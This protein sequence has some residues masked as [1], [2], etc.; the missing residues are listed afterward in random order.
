MIVVLL[1]LIGLGIMVFVH[2]LGHFVAA[3]ANG[4]AVEVF[5]LGWGPRLFGFKRGGTVYQ[6]SWFPIGGYCKMR[7]EITPGIAGGTGEQSQSPEASARKPADGS[8]N[9]APP[10]RRIIISAAGPLF[11]L[12]FAVIILSIIW[13]AGFNVTSY[14]NRIV[15]ATDYALDVSSQAP[16]ATAAGLKTGDRVLSIN[17]Q[18]VEN[19]QGI[20][21]AVTVAPNDRLL[22][23]ISREDGT[24]Q[25][26]LT[27]PVTP[28]L[29]KDSGAGQIGILPWVDPVV[30]TVLPKSPASN[31]ELQAGDRILKANG[32]A[33][34]NAWDIMRAL[35]DKPQKVVLEIERQKAVQSVPLVL[36]YGGTPQVGLD[37]SQKLLGV[38]FVVRQYHSPRL[39]PVGALNH[40]LG[41]T[42]NWVTVTV[43]GFGLLFQGIN[44]RNAVAG[45]LKIAR[46]IGDTAASGFQIGIGVGLTWTF[47][48]LAILSVVLFLMNLLPI[49]A[50]DGG[51]IILF[52]I[53]VVRGKAVP[54][55]LF[56]RIQVIGFSILLALIVVVTFNDILSFVAG[57]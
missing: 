17:G 30:Q 28:R 29:D 12:A 15:L 38:D 7:G 46:D 8:F 47:R 37:F 41:E 39:G 51:Q 49:P 6:V 2:E 21:E 4:V 54:A 40:G 24:S 3:K 22:F 50:M 34:S 55:N 1:G 48:L 9:A 5:S 26:T 20:R 32:T 56:W 44:L 57:R 27:L 45:P 16:P 36:E 42:W 14:D 11:N 23:T 18:P 33:V 19:F 52:L 31:A 53:E 43:K 25:R 35:A 10:L 13:W